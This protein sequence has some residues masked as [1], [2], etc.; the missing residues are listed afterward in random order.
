MSHLFINYQVKSFRKILI[1]IYEETK[2]NEWIKCIEHINRNFF[3]IDYEEGFDLDKVLKKGEEDEKNCTII[4][5][6]NT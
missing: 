3:F 4:P 5:T 6:I 2:K 1:L